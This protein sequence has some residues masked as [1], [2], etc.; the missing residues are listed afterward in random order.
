MI[1]MVSSLEN[2]ADSQPGD[3]RV[4]LRD[5]D[6]A[7]YR[8]LLAIRG[9]RRSP[10]IAYVD[11]VAELMT[12]SRGHESIG[13]KLGYLIGLYCS[14]RGITCDGAR[15]WT[16]NDE[17]DDAGLEPDDCFVFG[18]EPTPRTRPDLAV[19]VQWSRSALDKLE[20]YRRLGIAE[21][22]FWKQGKITVYA[23]G[24]AGYVTATNS[25]FLPD[26][27]LDVLC[28]CAQVAPATAAIAHFLASLRGG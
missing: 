21:V 10:R 22:W 26:L 20:I 16:L 27:D 9:E 28:R 12:P 19:E 11:G 8:S 23:L 15:S 24:D 17:S 13:Y 7:G 6:W 18:D 2:T 25:S 14:E 3:Q 4:V 5:V 1:A